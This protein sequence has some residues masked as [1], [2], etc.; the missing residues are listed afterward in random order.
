M[1]Y[2]PEGRTGPY[3]K[4]DAEKLKNYSFELGPIRPPSEGQDRS[5]LIRATRNCPWNRCEFCPIYKGKKFEYRSVEEIKRDIDTAKAL[6]D[7]IKAASWRLGYGG[8]V[9]HEVVSAII[10]GNPEVYG[11]DNIGPEVLAA[12]LESLVNVANW[13]SSGA[14]AVFLQ[15]ANTL[16]MRTPELIELLEYLKQTFPSIERV[17]SYARSKTAAKR[18]A[19]ELKELFEAGLSRLHIGLE[20]GCDEVLEEMQKGV[21]AEEHIKGGR[22]VVESGI[23]L[24][25]YVMPGLGG[26]RWSERHA[27]ETAK[28]LNQIN[29]DYIRIRSLI[30][31]KSMPLYDKLL[32]GKF[33]MLKEDELV[34]EIGLFIRNLDCSSYVVSDHMLNLLG[35]IEGQ[36]PQDKERMFKTVAEYQAMPLMERLRFRLKRRLGSYLSVYG[37]MNKSLNEKV[38]QAWESIT[39]ESPEAQDKVE[40]VILAL[41]EGFL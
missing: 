31:H 32:S 19:A 23:S 11:R 3:Y 18:S 40:D 41:R 13:L 37:G 2:H 38:Q 1:L 20:S 21:N 7:E 25:E 9:S 6:R 33:E 27:I 5:L 4:I 10:H 14:R 30:V 39:K 28:V 17:T 34:D 29:P 24:S 8:E 16:I 35:E 22:K 12:R 15:D 26:K 36:L